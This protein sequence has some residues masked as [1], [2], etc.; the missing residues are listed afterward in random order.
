MSDDAGAAAES[1]ARRLSN[2]AI[3]ADFRLLADL[4]EITGESVFKVAAYRRAAESIG[5]YPQ[6]LSTLRQQGRLRE[7]PGV[8]EEIAQKIGDLIDTGQL[9]LLERVKQEIPAGVARLLAVPGVGPKRARLLYESLGVDSIE[10]LRAAL[11]DGRLDRAKGLG[12]KTAQ[13]IAEGL[14]ALPV[15]DERVPLGRARAIGLALIE[16]LRQ[17]APALRRVELAGSIRRF[18]DKVGDIDIAAAAEQPRAVVEAFLALPAVARVEAQGETRAR[19]WLDSGIGA[20]LWVLPERHWGSLLVH[21]TGSRAH[22]IHLRNLALERGMRLSEYGLAAGERQLLCPQEADVYNALGLEEIPPPMREDTGEIQ[23]AAQG[24][25]PAVVRLGELRG[26]LHSHSQWSDGSRSI[27]EMALAA[28]ARG[29]D[30]LCL[31][32]HSQGLGVARGLSPERV[33]AQRQEIDAVN[34]ELA[35]FRVLQ[36]TELE[37]R[38]DG[39]LDFEDALLAAFDVVIASVHSGLQQG[40]ERVTA[41]ALAAIRHP[42]VDVLAHPTGRLVGGRVGGDFDLEAICREAARTGTALEIDGDPAR[43]DLRDTHARLALAA[44]CMLSIDSDAHAVEGLE[45]VFYGVGVAQRAWVPAERVLNTRAL[46]Q[47]LASLKRRRAERT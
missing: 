11:V 9:P 14:Q 46:P 31:T 28:R 32:D 1:G 43:L 18:G 39:S 41:R 42:L 26:D 45:N 16:A 34:A 4:L 2:G 15:E 12:A 5:D 25:L 20:D 24:R 8:G 21:T 33:R 17:R 10:A 40:R 44:G 37:V 30:Y 6:A 13:R 19:V 35:P 23:L 27:R 36:G 7:V 47:L 38:G 3:A 22:A 29:Y